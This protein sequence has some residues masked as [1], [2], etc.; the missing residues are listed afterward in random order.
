[1]EILEQIKKR[2][3]LPSD[4]NV[5]L[6]H[7][8]FVSKQDQFTRVLKWCQEQ[9]WETAPTYKF[10]GSEASTV[11]LFNNSNPEFEAYSRARDLLIIV[12]M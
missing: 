7:R 2:Y 1:M 6:L 11:I 5:V 12:E 8:K 4:R 10:M 3:C 9:N